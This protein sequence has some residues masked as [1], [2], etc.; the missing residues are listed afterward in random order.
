[1]CLEFREIG[2]MIETRSNGGDVIARQVLTRLLV[3][4]GLWVLL[5]AGCIL[6][7]FLHP[8]PVAYIGLA[9]LILWYVYIPLLWCVV[10]I[11]WPI[12]KKV[13]QLRRASSSLL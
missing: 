11:A 9:L 13:L 1:M 10:S 8:S 12:V 4:V 7:S 6:Y 5:I 2:G 3:A